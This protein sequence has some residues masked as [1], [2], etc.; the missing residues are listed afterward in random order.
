MISR[1]CPR[2][3]SWATFR[4]ALAGARGARGAGF[5]KK[6]FRH[7]VAVSPNLIQANSISQNLRPHGTCITLVGMPTGGRHNCRAVIRAKSLPRTPIRSLPRAPTRGLPRAPT[8]GPESSGMGIGGSVNADRKCV[9]IALMGFTERC[10]IGN[11]RYA[12][13]F[14]V[15]RGRV[16]EWL[17]PPDCK[18]GARKG[19]VGSNPTPSTIH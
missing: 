4:P 12:K 13:L 2:P 17:I 14:D 1:K 8:R 16:G 18:S 10:W 3:Q 11:C 15:D 7:E 19:Y 9:V 6:L 5:L